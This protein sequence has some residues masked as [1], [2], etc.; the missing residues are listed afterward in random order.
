MMD[1]IPLLL[2]VLPYIQ[3]FRDKT[4]V[5]K[6]G[7]NV[8]SDEERLLSLSKDI[9]ILYNLGIKI[10]LVHG[11]AKQVDEHLN[12]I[13]HEPEKIDGRRITDKKAIDVA[14]MI[15]GGKLNSE[16]TASLMSVGVS[17]I[18][19]KGCDG[20]TVMAEKRDIVNICDDENG[21]AKEVDFGYVGDITEINPDLLTMLLDNGYLPVISCLATDDDGTILNVNADT[22]AKEI[23]VAIDS[24][25][26][27]LLTDVP[28]VLEDKD[29]PSS[30]ISYMTIEEAEEVYR[31]SK[32]SGGMIP[33]LQ[34]CINAVKEGV[35]Q[36]HIIEGIKEHTLLAELFTNQ[37][38]GTMIEGK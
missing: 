3:N 38:I 10:V 26:M 21:V 36:V 8:I 30:I 16:I 1:K 33:K 34:N 28:G 37:G 18:G 27:I 15:Y 6:L 25:K 2:E 32:I 13:S 22:I 23:A 35:N 19:L 7:G 20:G 5:I 17:S 31:S 11:G 4:F 14:K 24:E 9:S 29:N 12:K